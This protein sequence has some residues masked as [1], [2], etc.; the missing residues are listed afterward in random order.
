M[1]SI[2]ETGISL[3]LITAILFVAWLSGDADPLGESQEEARLRDSQSF[4]LSRNGAT[5]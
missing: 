5:P 3:L 1:K 4:F 2:L